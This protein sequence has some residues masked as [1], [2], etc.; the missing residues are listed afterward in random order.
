MIEFLGA[1]LKLTNERS[2][3]WI[4]EMDSRS[5]GKLWGRDE[6]GVEEG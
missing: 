1:R 5:E 4:L 2:M 3:C 6:E